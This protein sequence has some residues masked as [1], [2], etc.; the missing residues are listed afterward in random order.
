MHK[1]DE[2]FLSNIALAEVRHSFHKI[3]IFVDKMLKLYSCEKFLIHSILVNLI[4]DSKEHV[5]FAFNNSGVLHH[6][7]SEFNIGLSMVIE[8]LE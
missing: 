6:V 3:P 8:I 1:I 7:P 4:K 5:W 2:I